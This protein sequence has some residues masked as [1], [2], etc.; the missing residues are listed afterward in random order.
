MGL[1]RPLTDDAG[2]RLASAQVVLTDVNDVEVLPEQIR[3]DFF[4]FRKVFC[5]VDPEIIHE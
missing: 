1:E 2:S 4:E 5:R 3:N